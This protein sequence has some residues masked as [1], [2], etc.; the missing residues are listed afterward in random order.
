MSDTRHAMPFN[1]LHRMKVQNRRKAEQAALD[2]FS[3]NNVLHRH[4]NRLKSYWTQI[5]EPWDDKRHSAWKEYHNKHYYDN[6]REVKNHY[7]RTKV[8][9]TDF[10]NEYEVVTE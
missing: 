2:H 1:C 3:T 8:D 10:C 5:P 7:T 6:W 4:I 9:S